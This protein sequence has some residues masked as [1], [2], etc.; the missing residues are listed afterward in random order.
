MKKFIMKKARFITCPTYVELDTNTP[1]G[2]GFYNNKGVDIT[3]FDDI[4][5][6]VKTFTAQKSVSRATLRAT[7]L[8]TFE[9]YLNG[10]RVGTDGVYDEMK[11][12]ATDYDYHLFAYTYDV[13]GL[14][15]EDNT[16]VGQVATG[17]RAGRMNRAYYKNN[18]TAFCCELELE[19]ADGT[20]DIIATDE[21]WLSTSDGNIKTADIWD[22]WYCD[23]R[24]APTWIST[25]GK[26]MVACNIYEGD[27]PELIEPM[28]EEVRVDYSLTRKPLSA[29]VHCGSI[30]NGSDYGKIRVVSQKVGSG[31]EKTLLRRG[32]SIILDLGQNM[33]GRP[34]FEI[35]AQR[36]TT[37][38]G[39]VAE[40]L[41]DSGMENRGND[42]PEGSM[43]IKNYRSAL[44][45][46]LYIANGN[47][48]ETVYPIHVF[49]GFRYFEITADNDIEILSF[50]GLVMK[51]DLDGTGSFTCSDAEV[52]KL[53]SNVIWGL[54]G[55]YLSIPTDCPQR[56]ERYG[57]T[58]D[59]Q[60]FAN[61]GSYLVNTK[62][63][64][65][66]WLA[67]A[68]DSQNGFGGAYCCVIPRVFTSEGGN[69]AW[70]DAG[71]VVPD[72]LYRMYNDTDI[73]SAH[74]ES[75]CDYMNYIA[76]KN[77]LNGPNTA[78]G[79]WLNYE[80]T[81]NRYIAVCYYA[82]DASLMAKFSGVLAEKKPD[83]KAFY[84]TKKAEFEKLFEEIK[85]F[86]LSEFFSDGNLNEN[87][88]TQTTY[89]LALKF[90][91]IPD[92]Y[93]AD[94]IKALEKKIIDNNYT[95][96][97]GF[98]GTGVLCGTLQELGLYDLAYDLLLQ[99]DD[100]SWLYSVRQG[101][102]TIWERWNSYTKARG[103]GD[104]GM[105]SFNHYAYGAVAQWMFDGICGI[106]PDEKKPGFEESFVLCPTP[107]MRSFIPEGQQRMTHAAATYKT[108]K[109]TISSAWAIENGRHVYSFTIPEGLTARVGILNKKDE[110]ISVNDIIISSDELC[111]NCCDGRVYFTLGS[112]EYTVK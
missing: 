66:K 21:S 36:G 17:W 52:N 75:M 111:H 97:T 69:A 12:Q 45:R 58:G 62:R 20:T 14:I 26:N 43:Y 104:V 94:C 90:G 23:G 35:K 65:E 99:S 22:G 4:S 38:K 85:A 13:T 33:V 42:G 89:L 15:A 77:G 79:D 78:Y 5:D 29:T 108:A 18:I 91:L 50:S 80:E 63:F 81:D 55:N 6:Y 40:M 60:I 100:P 109:G 72:V 44:A 8:G 1:W 48:T 70:A 67:D 93:R 32:E 41:N 107:D 68:R 110:E 103:F 88:R 84:L 3:P 112:G 24:I 83:K 47:D 11:P 87:M 34:C 2:N 82:Y 9:L 54:R 102:T 53:F 92:E 98:V 28:C 105:N 10:Q 16:L 61:A 30:D 39:Y 106:K 7:A 86:F 31:C 59:T 37:V 27:P 57:W 74:Y 25:E 49:Y 51:S 56:D 71:I 96:S 19:Y 101:A 76:K 73:L 95:L 46:V 64:F